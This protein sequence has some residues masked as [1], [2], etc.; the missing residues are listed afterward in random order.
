MTI[1]LIQ[2]RTLSMWKGLVNNDAREQEQVRSDPGKPGHSPLIC[3]F[4]VL[5][6]S[7]PKA[8]G[9]KWYWSSNNSAFIDSIVISQ[10]NWTCDFRWPLES[11]QIQCPNNYLSASVLCHAVS[12]LR[13][14]CQTDNSEIVSWVLQWPSNKRKN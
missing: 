7:A 11:L 6:L 5:P 1:F 4:P 3:I 14:F 13:Y 12:F 8:N 10:Q 2:I 9:W